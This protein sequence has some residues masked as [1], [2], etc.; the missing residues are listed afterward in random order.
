MFYEEEQGGILSCLYS[1]PCRE[2]SA[3]QLPRTDPD[4]F[5][6][7][8]EGVVLN[9]LHGFQI[10]RLNEKV[11]SCEE[12]HESFPSLIRASACVSEFVSLMLPT[13]DTDQ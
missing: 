10:G 6:I 8:E 7:D 2:A 12:G 11:R 3:A 13:K 5:F 4:G 1:V 9:K